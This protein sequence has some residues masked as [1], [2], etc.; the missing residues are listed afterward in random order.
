VQATTSS[1]P[2]QG[3]FWTCRRGGRPLRARRRRRRQ[4][5]P[6]RR[7]RFRRDRRGPGDDLV[8]LGEDAP[9]PEDEVYST[10]LGGEGDDHL[11]G[12]GGQERLF[13]GPG[14]DLLEGGDGTDYLFGEDGDD[15]VHGEGGDDESLDGGRG[16]DLVEG[17]RGDDGLDAFADGV[18]TPTGADPGMTCSAGV[19][20]R[21]GRAT[22]SLAVRPRHRL[23]GGW[24]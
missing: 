17:G 4:R 23:R 15:S 3:T 10:A 14:N 6:V 7:G 1:A 9:T 2:G 5:P 8:D 12:G 21:R 20:R 18:R 16:I 11:V 19:S 24:A 22:P 13:G